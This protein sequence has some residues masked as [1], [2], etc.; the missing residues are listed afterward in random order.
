MD[1]NY[2]QP[3]SG[4]TTVDPSVS[5]LGFR[6]NSAR[7]SANLTFQPDRAETGST[8]TLTMVLDNGQTLATTINGG[9]VNLGL[10]GPATSSSVA[11]AY[12]GDNLNALA[13]A[14]APSAHTRHLPDVAAAGFEQPRHDHG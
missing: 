3:G 14:M 11:L 8:L 9:A 10:R 1:W 2:L 5:P 13:N 7:T 6:L 12:P 4:A